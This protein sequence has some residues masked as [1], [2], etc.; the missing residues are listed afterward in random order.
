MSTYDESNDFDL[1]SYMAQMS[2]EGV[3]TKAQTIPEGLDS[4]TGIKL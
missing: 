4:L 1:E 2:E 3:V